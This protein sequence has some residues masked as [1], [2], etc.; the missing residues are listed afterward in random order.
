MFAVKLNFT[1]LNDSITEWDLLS[2]EPENALFFIAQPMFKVGRTLG[3]YNGF[4]L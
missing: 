1:Q 4:V 3:A 2:A